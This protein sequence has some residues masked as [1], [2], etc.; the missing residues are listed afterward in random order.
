MRIARTFLD[1]LHPQLGVPRSIPAFKTSP[2]LFTQL[3][4]VH[5]LLED[6]WRIPCA[7]TLYTNPSK[8]DHVP[9]YQVVGSK[10][11]KSFQMIGAL[12]FVLPDMAVFAGYMDYTWLGTSSSDFLFDKLVWNQWDATICGLPRSSNLAEGW[13][14]GFKSIV[15]CTNP[16][17]W[18]FMDAL[19]L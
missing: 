16:T 11:R 6:G 5:G 12:P 17:I 14:N 7:Q 2:N 1:W 18:S 13:H 15:N 9:E 8:T 19:K 3:L 10:V 4:T